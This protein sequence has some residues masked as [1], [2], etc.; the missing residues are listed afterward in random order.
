MF[1]SDWPVVEMAASYGDWW[2]AAQ[3]LT[4]ALSEPERQALFGGTAKRFYRL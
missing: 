2:A 1:G 3:E 4:S